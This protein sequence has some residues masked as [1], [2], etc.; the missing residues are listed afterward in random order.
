MATKKPVPA[1][2]GVRKKMETDVDHAI[3]FDGVSISQLSR[4]FGL[5][6]RDIPRKIKDLQP[7]GSRVGYPI[8]DLAE[9][10]AYLIPPK[11]DFE[12]AIK[13]MSA[14]DLPVLLV[15]EFWAGQHA[16]LKYEED[17]GD[18]W[19]T[20]DVAEMVQD[21]TKTMRMS[22]MLLR[23]KLSRQTELTQRQRD[24]LRTMID[25]AL[26]EMAKAVEEKFKNDPER[27][28]RD[29]QWI[30]PDAA[31]PNDPAAGL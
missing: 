8:Y 5:D 19:R 31:D 4:I 30:D 23:D 6:N 28:S 22:V 13:K 25:G 14:K 15:K 24:L 29:G 27:K 1:T 26:N 20:A 11:G 3:I 21:L 7:C 18:L 2:T 17:Q 12:E 16:R 9:A 10:A